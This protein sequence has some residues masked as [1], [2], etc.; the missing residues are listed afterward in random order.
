V[1]IMKMLRHPNIIRLYEVIDTEEFLFLIMEHASGGEMMDII[2]S[3]GRLKEAEARKYFAQAAYALAYCHSHHTVHRDVKAEN[4]LLDDNMNVKLIDFGF[5]NIYDPTN[6]LQTFCG[7][8]TYASPELVQRH[9][10]TGP[11]VD[12][13]SLG[14]LLY[15]LVSGELPFTGDTYLELYQKIVSA[16]Y[17]MPTYLTPAC[18]DLILNMLQ[19]DPENRLNIIQICNHPWV[20]AGHLTVPAENFST[21]QTAL[22][23]E[24]LNKRVLDYMESL[25][26]DRETVVRSVVEAKYDDAAATYYLMLEASPRQRSFKSDAGR[27]S[28]GSLSPSNAK[29][30]PEGPSEGSEFSSIS[31]ES[32]PEG[33]KK[34]SKDGKS[35]T[36]SG[37]KKGKKERKNS[38]AEK[39]RSNSVKLGLLRDPVDDID[40][41]EKTPIITTEVKDEP[42]DSPKSRKS[43]RKV[44]PKL[45]AVKRLQDCTHKAPVSPPSPSDSS[46]KANST[47]QSRNSLDDSSDSKRKADSSAQ[48]RVTPAC[49]SESGSSRMSS[50]TGDEHEGNTKAGTSQQS[51]HKTSS[52][53]P[54]R[55]KYVRTPYAK[56]NS[57][58]SRLRGDDVK[59]TRS[60]P[61]S[62]V[63]SPMAVEHTVPPLVEMETRRC[64]D[65]DD[66]DDDDTSKS[67]SKKH[68]H[69]HHHHHH[70]HRCR[71]EQ[72]DLTTA[73]KPSPEHD[74]LM[75]TERDDD[76]DSGMTKRDKVSD[77]KRK[78][79][80]TVDLSHEQE[81]VGA[82]SKE[83]LGFGNT[84]GSLYGRDKAEDGRRESV[85]TDAYSSLSETELSSA[86]ISPVTNKVLDCIH[87]LKNVLLS[88]ELLKI[89]E[90][91]KVLLFFLLQRHQRHQNLLCQTAEMLLQSVLQELH[92]KVTL[93]QSRMVVKRKHPTYNV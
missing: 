1:A 92:I 33:D 73:D 43:S 46:S 55:K 12:C 45:L 76:D 13:W 67:S 70:H 47:P 18:K 7:S 81:T 93:I 2:L 24:D 9:A 77:P 86:E 35:K 5:S 42:V 20:L 34:G 14:V 29:V 6:V 54:G 58:S 60:T 21:M 40:G 61:A 50:L 16:A 84:A 39:R 63:S 23:E 57:I 11:E 22:K 68:K 64:D 82:R 51:S 79:S 66:D 90:V 44:P 71:P 28:S 4:M 48:S 25:G 78:R 17:K 3:H 65:D 91:A 75:S 56:E 83:C 19:P 59:G 38:K 10:Y 32:N 85:D 31:T 8:P 26:F 69:H 15:V 52:R 72:K 49:S 74:K 62:P 37:D 53:S 30:S 80:S 41:V 89:K 27:S 88:Q 36:E 87:Q